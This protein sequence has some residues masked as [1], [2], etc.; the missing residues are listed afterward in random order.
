MG[1]YIMKKL[2]KL[3]MILALISV[4]PAF[5]AMVT[6]VNYNT[7][8]PALEAKLSKGNNLNTYDLNQIISY[9]RSTDKTLSP[10]QKAEL[11]K[12]YKQ[13]INIA[14]SKANN[15]YKSGDYK[16]A[17][18][19]YYIVKSNYRD[20]DKSILGTVY[21]NMANCNVQAGKEC[22]GYV[23]DAIIL[24]SADSRITTF[25]DNNPKSFSYQNY[26]SIANRYQNFKQ[27]SNALKYYNMAYK[28]APSEVQMKS[29]ERDIEECK[30]MQSGG[31]PQPTTVKPSNVNQQQ[32]ANSAKVSQHL[33]AAVNKFNYGDYSGALNSL[34][35]AHEL[36]PNTNTYDVIYPIIAVSSNSYE[37]AKNGIDK[38]IT[39][40]L[41]PFRP[42]SSN[43]HYAYELRA[44]LKLYLKDYNGAISDFN[45]AVNCAS[46]DY[47]DAYQGLIIA[48][49]IKGDKEN[50]KVVIN[51]YNRLNTYYQFAD[52][53]T[54]P[55]RIILNFGYNKKVAYSPNLNNDLIKYTIKQSQGEYAY[56]V[57]NLYSDLWG[58]EYIQ[59]K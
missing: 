29:I 10:Q 13:A 59:I 36:A 16:N 28:N 41:G 17:Y 51:K 20:V 42:S 27:Y 8:K 5:A 38:V 2:Y 50:A 46:R 47:D 55:D 44:A 33:K 48:Y 11:E 21:L 53:T 30:M 43:L 52:C 9:A 15:Y 24:N 49:L 56:I 18:S 1:L 45:S 57:S 54:Y 14:L 22:I 3:L 4:L 34:S 7:E 23:I 39:Q 37:S 32:A 26:K 58:G 31:R 6:S 25:I 35:Q 40:Q 12:I 19:Y